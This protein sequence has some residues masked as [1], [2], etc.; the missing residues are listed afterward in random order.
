M[1]TRK[2][3]SAN[4]ID[5]VFENNYE[6]FKDFYDENKNLIYKSILEIFKGFTKTRKK[7]LTLHLSAKI[8]EYDWDTEF[9]FSRNEIIVLKRDLM[10]YFEEIED[11]ETC[12]E[13]KNLYRQFSN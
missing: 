8:K 4:Y 5:L 2:S 10:P 6:D 13:I 7:S 1:T 12:N 11:Y 9:N 3:N